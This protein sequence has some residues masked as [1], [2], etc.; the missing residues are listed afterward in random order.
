[1][2][3]DFSEVM[4][5]L[6]GIQ[7]YLLQVA[8]YE[9]FQPQ[10]IIILEKDPPDLLESLNSLRD[11]TSKRKLRYPLLVT[12]NFV[13]SSLDSFPLE[14]LDI[15]AS[16]YENLYVKKDILKKLKFEPADIR[17][18]ME[19]EIKGKWLLIRLSVLEKKNT[20]KQLADILALTLG[21]IVRVLKGICYLNDGSVPQ[22]LE[23]LFIRTTNITDVDFDVMLSC[24]TTREATLANVKQYLSVIEDIMHYI[25][26]IKL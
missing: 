15:T 1:M 21:N 24:L 4:S 2:K 5:T 9:D 3:N 14:F 25:E 16:N 22:T 7:D 6:T 10:C 13:N 18:Q 26:H 23:D 17:L 19:R 11:Y 8:V 20:P 12:R